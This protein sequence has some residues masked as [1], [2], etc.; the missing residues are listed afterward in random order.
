MCIRDR[1]IASVAGPC[2]PA[3]DAMDVLIQPLATANAGPDQVTCATSPTV[4]LAASF[5]GAATGGTW[6]GG[7][8][9]FSP[10]AN[11]WNALYTPASSELAAGSATLTWTTNDPAGPCRAA[12][13][14]VKITFDSP[15]VVVPSKVTC[16]D[17][18]P[19]TLCASPSRGIAPY[20]YRWSNG[21]TTQCISV[22][23]TGSYAVTI[24]DAQGCTASGT[25][26]FTQREC[27]GQLTHTTATCSSFMD[28]TAAD[29]SSGDINVQV[30]DG[31]ITNISPG[32][33]FY[34]CL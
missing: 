9:T 31:V 10:N 29:F 2:G 25:G 33:F 3:T 14:Q 26:R 27:I 32:V 4:R 28:G 5:G 34:C 24:V 20:T 15:L 23:D 21:A 7:W 19:V 18:A 16:T 12:S 11:T 8:G 30:R 17:V 6:S 13:D 1:S 22:A